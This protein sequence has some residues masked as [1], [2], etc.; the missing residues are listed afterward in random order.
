[1]SLKGGSQVICGKL[2]IE[3]TLEAQSYEARPQTQYRRR[4][5]PRLSR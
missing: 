4:L 2:Q 1:M 3:G 5:D